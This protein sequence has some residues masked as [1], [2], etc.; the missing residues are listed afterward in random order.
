MRTVTGSNLRNILLLTNKMR[1]D[2]LE[3]SLVDSISYHKLE[4]NDKWRVR[5]INGLIDIKH[6]DL[7]PPEGWS[8]EDLELIMNFACTQ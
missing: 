5:M 8:A 1:V 2:D 7:L 6:G 3:P 4:E